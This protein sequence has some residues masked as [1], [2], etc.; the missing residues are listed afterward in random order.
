MISSSRVVENRERQTKPEIA[1]FVHESFCWCNRH[2]F[3]RELFL[4]CT[5]RRKCDRQMQQMLQMQ[6]NSKSA[7][8]RDERCKSKCSHLPKLLPTFLT[9]RRVEALFSWGE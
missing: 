2:P 1:V 8:Q 7:N 3:P 5:R 4:Q 6:R 9:K